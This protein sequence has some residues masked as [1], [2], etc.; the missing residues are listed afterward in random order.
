M[1]LCVKAL[2]VVVFVVRVF[3]CGFYF[4]PLGFVFGVWFNTFLALLA[5]LRFR[6]LA[7][8]LIYMSTPAIELVN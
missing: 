1:F 3:I 8:A 7:D 6:S 2:V 4:F 5:V